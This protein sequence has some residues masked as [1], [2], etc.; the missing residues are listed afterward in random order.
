MK[1]LAILSAKKL[2]TL[3]AVG[4]LSLA[5]VGG[6]MLSS[7]NEEPQTAQSSVKFEGEVKESPTAEI[8][9]VEKVVVEPAVKEVVKPVEAVE[10]K[11]I[12][13]PIKEAVVEPVQKPVDNP[14]EATVLLKYVDEYLKEN[15]LG[16]GDYS[17]SKYAHT[18]L[19]ISV[20]NRSH[21]T[22]STYQ[23]NL[24]PCLDELTTYIKSDPKASALLFTCYQLAKS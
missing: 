6:V 12:E 15:G 20:N 21:F 22:E 2:I 24:R 18:I 10:E 14:V 19:N 8:V 4:V 17:F 11:E 5:T 9:E 1:R 3:S 23:N 7:S 13:A 16:Y